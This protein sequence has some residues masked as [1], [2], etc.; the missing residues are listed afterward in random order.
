[1]TGDKEQFDTL[2]IKKLGVVT[3]GDNDKGH[4]IRVGKIQ[5]TPST[6]IENILY[7][8][9]LKHNLISISQLYDKGYKVL[10][11]ALLCIKTDPINDSIIFIGHR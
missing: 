3:F 11:E 5:I 9:G 6:F 4:I 8:R 10:F 7:V 2:E 1:M